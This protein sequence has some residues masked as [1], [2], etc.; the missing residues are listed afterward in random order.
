ME[1]AF[2]VDAAYNYNQ[3]TGLCY[4]DGLAICAGF[5]TSHI[6]LEHRIW[7]STITIV[8]SHGWVIR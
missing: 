8:G 2:V 6:I 1:S 7:C 4:Y 3:K 5:T